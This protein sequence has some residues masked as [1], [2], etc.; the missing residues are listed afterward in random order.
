MAAN[1]EVPLMKFE[2]DASAPILRYDVPSP[3]SYE[4]R[5][6]IQLNFGDDFFNDAAK[7]TK[8]TL[9]QFLT[10]NQ[11]EIYEYLSADTSTEELRRLFHTF[12]LGLRE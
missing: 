8:P 9:E 10:S 4:G 12:E 1:D 7:P 11:E 5:T 2:A 6:Y 3:S